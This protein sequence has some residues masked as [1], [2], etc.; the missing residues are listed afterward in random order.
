[1]ENLDADAVPVQH[2]FIMIRYFA[3]YARTAQTENSLWALVPNVIPTFFFC[4]LFF[5]FKKC[6]FM[7]FDKLFV[8]IFLLAHAHCVIISSL[9]TTAGAQ[10][11]RPNLSGHEYM[12]IRDDL[13]VL[14]NQRA[15]PTA[16]PTV[17]RIIAR[18][19]FTA[20]STP[21]IGSARW[22]AFTD[23][24][25]R[26]CLILASKGIVKYHPLFFIIK[27]GFKYSFLFFLNNFSH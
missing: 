2:L 6:C 14:R 9:L 18:Y 13:K 25:K 4:L 27:K 26:R 23:A 15:Y 19:S 11:V 12:C 7:C 1:L 3:D 10:V 20:Q 22:A 24:E 17:Q 16:G 8:L 21:H 5:V